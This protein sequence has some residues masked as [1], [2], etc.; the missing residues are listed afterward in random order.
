M[1]SAL[2]SE[3]PSNY[4]IDPDKFMASMVEYKTKWLHAKANGL[5]EPRLPEYAGKCILQIA[6]R[7][8]RH[9]N[10]L[11]KYWFIEEM[12]SDGIENCLLY[13]YNFDPAKGKPFSYFTQIVYFAFLRR[14]HREKVHT[15]TR[16]KVKQNMIQEGLAEVSDHDYGED[17]GIEVNPENE[18]MQ[19]FVRNFESREKGAKQKRAK[20]KRGVENFIETPVEQ[21]TF[22]GIE[23]AV[24]DEVVEHAAERATSFLALDQLYLIQG[25]LIPEYVVQEGSEDKFDPDNKIVPGWEPLGIEE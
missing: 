5:K 18:F 21:E 12:I 3:L 10:F 13:A 19:E 2:V 22:D 11:N 16:Y 6:K 8:A 24:L 15:Y 1:E 25:G 23:E 4:Y 14:I 9:K 7:L 17:Y 20:K